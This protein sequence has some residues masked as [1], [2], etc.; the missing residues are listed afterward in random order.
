V[1]AP[2]EQETLDLLL[3]GVPPPEIAE[4]LSLSYWTVHGHLREIRQ[5]HGV[6][7]AVGLVA[8]IL[9]ERIEELTRER[10]ACLK[11]LAVLDRRGRS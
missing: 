9:N 10:D 1:N 7:T 3:Q 4:R 11:D 5:R 8:K 6:S 2:R